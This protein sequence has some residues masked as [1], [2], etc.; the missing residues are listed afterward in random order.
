MRSNQ[1]TLIH[2]RPIVRQA[3]RSLPALLADGSPRPTTASSHSVRTPSRSRSR[4]T[5]EDAI[6]LSE[7]SSRTR[8]AHLDPHSRVRD[9]ARSTLATRR[10]PAI[11]NRSEESLRNLDDR[12]I[13]R[14]GAEV[15]SATCSSARSPRRADRADR[16]GEADPRHLREKAREV[17][18]LAEGPARRGRVVIDVKTFSRQRRRPQPRRER[19]GACHVAKKRKISEGDKLAGRTGNKGVSRRSSPRRTCSSRT[20]VRR[21]PAPPARRAGP[22]DR[23]RSPKG[24]SLVGGARRLASD[25]IEPMDSNAG[26]VINGRSRPRSPRARCSTAP[27]SG[28]STP[29]CSSGRSR[30]RTA[31]SRS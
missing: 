5:T 19:A 21:H 9:D 11:P 1:G 27:R 2:H 6:V 29:R 23:P 16:R 10:S 18:D 7:R 12:G 3:T 26:R 17:H 13:V 31:R 20:G 22:P 30:T 15:G 25:E 4:A 14:V 28:T 8:G 24:I